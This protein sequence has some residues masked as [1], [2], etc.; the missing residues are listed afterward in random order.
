MSND[1]GARPVPEGRLVLL[2][3]GETEWSRA[4]KHTGLTDVPLTSAG[5]E[6]ARRSAPLLAEFDFGLVLVSPK[7][8]ARRTAE[9]V[10]LT[11]STVEPNLVEWDYGGYEGRTTTEIRE[12]LGYDWTVWEDGVVPGDSPGESIE[13]VAARARAVIDRVMPVLEEGKDVALVGHGHTNRVLTSV[14]LRTE[15]RF[16]A[17]LE[18]DAGSICVLAYERHFP[19]IARWNQPAPA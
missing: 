16:G 14:W 11:S 5:E 2:R 7:E 9:L 3:H 4:M 19:S 1:T 15:P 18:L 8:R 6:A 13:Q 10:G 12:E 17:Q